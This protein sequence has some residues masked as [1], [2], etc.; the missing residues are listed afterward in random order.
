MGANG[1][2]TRYRIG[3]YA[4]YMGVTPDF[5]K[6]YEQLGLIT[7]FVGENGYRHYPFAESS[8]LLSCLSLRS[9]G[10]PLKEIEPMLRKD[11]TEAFCQ[12][13]DA[14]A[15]ALRKQ[16][17]FD[18]AIVR[19]HEQLSRW[20]ARM[21]GRMEDWRVAE[22]PACL[23][24]PHTDLYTFL[25]DARI[26][27]LL[28][29]WT[30]YMPMV[31]SCLRITPAEGGSRPSFCWGLAVPEEIAVAHQ[32]PTNDIVERLPARKV[33]VLDYNGLKH[34]PEEAPLEHRYRHFLSRMQALNLHP[35][36]PVFQ[37]VLFHTHDADGI[38]QEHGYMTAPVD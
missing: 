31:K 6:H 36:G 29:V 34:L 32:L 26:Y 7:P 12:K 18:Q 17:A 23:F 33:F 35:T 13:L 38:V 8:R 10:I 19:E 11:D 37:T 27:D 25:G 5:L 14:Y 28:S 1:R 4:R 20:I 30:S 24:L 9:Y 21:D 3:D 16:I 15:D 22:L 2:T